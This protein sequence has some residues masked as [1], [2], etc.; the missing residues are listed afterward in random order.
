MTDKL[1]TL[2]LFPWYVTM[3]VV[4]VVVHDVLELREELGL[5]A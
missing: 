4:G 5:R 2:A 3:R 1:I